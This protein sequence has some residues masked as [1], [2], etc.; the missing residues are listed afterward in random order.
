MKY[1]DGYTRLGWSLI[2]LALLGAF[3]FLLGRALQARTAYVVWTGIG[4]IGTVLMGVKARPPKCL[5]SFQS[6]IL[7]SPL[8]NAPK[9]LLVRWPRRHTAQGTY[10]LRATIFE[11]HHLHKWRHIPPHVMVCPGMSPIAKMR[12]GET[13]LDDAARRFAQRLMVN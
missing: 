10:E 8:R 6:L 9:M 2:S 11:A 5:Q 3:V 4:A 12:I 13:R 7:I 1:A